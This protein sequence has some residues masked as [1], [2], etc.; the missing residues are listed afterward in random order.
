MFD[1][2]RKAIK[3]RLHRFWMMRL[4][5]S[6]RFQKIYRD[7]HWGG[8]S[9]ESASGLGSSFQ[10]TEAIRAELPLLVQKFGIRKLLDLGCGDFN[11]MKH[12][13]LPV[14]YIGA[15]IV[16]EVIENNR[17][18]YGNDAIDFMVLDGIKD[19]IPEDVDAILC[20]EVLF[21]LSFEHALALL[22]NVKASNA[23]Y[24]I[25]TQI[26]SQTENQDT[27]TGG[28]RPLDLRKAPFGFPEPLLVIP[29][30]RVSANR[31]LCLWQL[32][33]ISDG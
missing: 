3:F 19:P 33:D 23:R 21:H 31:S 32:S 30:D 25:A 17:R 22:A 18:L 9:S 26:D 11:W 1:R 6:A 4:P 20:R 27:F 10:A 7:R 13:E 15:D 5:V 8:S 12:V 16:S 2:V 29:D 14:P 24:L 28:F